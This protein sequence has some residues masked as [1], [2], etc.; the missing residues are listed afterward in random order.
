[1]AILRSISGRGPIAIVL[2]VSVIAAFASLD[3]AHAQPAAS[4]ENWA[5]ARARSLTEQGRAHRQSGDTARAVARFSEALAIDATFGEAYLEL[6]TT[7]E[8]AGE[9]DEAERVLAISL[10]RIPG[11]VEGMWA[12]GE[13]YGRARRY[14]EA[15]SAFLHVSAAKPDDEPTLHKILI[16]ATRAGLFPVALA[17]ARRLGAL[18]EKRDD[19]VAAKD[20]RLTTKALA[21][22]VA[23]ADPVSTG[24]KLSDPIRRALAAAEAR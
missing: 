1:M 18:A 4:Q 14:P 17:A 2:V 13:L 7:R 3:G 5:T 16:N 23:E 10:E 15:T 21:K 6:A 11:F 20:A 12:R 19:R 9:T 22:L 24:V 8:A